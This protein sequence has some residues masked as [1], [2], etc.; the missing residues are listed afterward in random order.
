MERRRSK[1]ST[2]TTVPS[3][4]PLPDDGSEGQR[5]IRF[6]LVPLGVRRKVIE[7]WTLP[8]GV[9][10]LRDD[11]D[12]EFIYELQAGA[13]DDPDGV[14]ILRHSWCESAASQVAGSVGAVERR[15]YI[16]CQTPRSAS[17]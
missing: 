7:D 4:S 14:S 10:H 17:F 2:D 1:R 5:N 9:T 8:T 16:V 3:R 12:T 11:V 13:Y 15:A 6:H